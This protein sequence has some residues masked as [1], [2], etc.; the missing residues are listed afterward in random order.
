MNEASEYKSCI[1]YKESIVNYCK[2]NGNKT[3]CMKKDSLLGSTVKA[4]AGHEFKTPMSAIIGIASLMKECAGEISKEEQL[5]FS[6]HI[7]MSA[8]RLMSNSFRLSAWFELKNQPAKALTAFNF[9]SAKLENLIKD[10]AISQMVNGEFFLFECEQ[11][12]FVLNGDENILFMS[13]GEL[14][15][16]AFKFSP[17]DSVVKFS[18]KKVKNTLQLTISNISE[19]VRSFDFAKYEVFTQF[20]RNYFE[21]Q[22][23]GLGLEIA[24]LGI[25]I[26]KGTLK[27]DVQ[28]SGDESSKVNCTVLLPLAP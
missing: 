22:G 24:R 5:V 4:F 7:L 18:V 3:H 14:I 2:E 26:C 23:L 1:W 25:N 11:E 20:D 9:T 28:S 19:K 6:N 13:I 12:S 17:K 21:Q 15:D 16:N 27:I 8:Q 10:K